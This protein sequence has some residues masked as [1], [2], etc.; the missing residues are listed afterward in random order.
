MNTN[1][2]R[3]GFFGWLAAAAAGLAVGVVDKVSTAEEPASDPGSATIGTW[4][5]DE[6]KEDGYIDRLLARHGLPSS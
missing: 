5:K 4:Y 2:D 1:T 6:W 3:R